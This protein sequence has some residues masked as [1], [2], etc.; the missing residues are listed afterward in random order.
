M[1]VTSKP[2][3]HSRSTIL[4]RLSNPTHP[5]MH[6][7]DRLPQRQ[8][9]S[10]EGNKPDEKS[11]GCEQGREALQKLFPPVRRIQGGGSHIHRADG[12]TS[13]K[14]MCAV[15]GDPSPANAN[16]I[17]HTC[18]LSAR[19]EMNAMGLAGVGRE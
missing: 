7:G 11:V 5:G 6:V 1:M 13:E 8:P 18:F 10:R 16:T 4:Y 15:D 19:G 14:E 12:D 2:Q 3:T 17:K 9:I